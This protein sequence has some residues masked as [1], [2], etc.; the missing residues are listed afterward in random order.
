MKKLDNVKKRAPK[1]KR[2]TTL[3]FS[4]DELITLARY[5]SFGKILLQRDDSVISRI[6]GA[7]SR[8]GMSSPE[9]L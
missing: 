7:L 2:G 9:G 6:K 1:Q 8:L 3:T 4:A 5:V